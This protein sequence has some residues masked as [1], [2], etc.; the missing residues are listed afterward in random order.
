[1]CLHN[2][3]LYK[4]P[5]TDIHNNNIHPS[6]SNTK[7]RVQEPKHSIQS[8]RIVTQIVFYKKL[9]WKN[10]SPKRRK[11]M[12]GKEYCKTKDLFKKWKKTCIIKATSTETRKS[13]RKIT[14]E[15]SSKK[16]LTVI[17][18]PFMEN[19]QLHSFQPL[20]PI[21]IN[22]GTESSAQKLSANSTEV[23]QDKIELNYCFPNKNSEDSGI[24]QQTSGALP[25]LCNNRVRN[26]VITSVQQQSALQLFQANRDDFGEAY[27]QVQSTKED[28]D[29]SDQAKL[30]MSCGR[31]SVEDSKSGKDK[32]RCRFSMS[33]CKEMEGSKSSENGTCMSKSMKIQRNMEFA[34]CKRLVIDE[35]LEESVRKIRSTGTQTY[36]SFVDNF[37]CCCANARILERTCFEEHSSVNT[38]CKQPDA[39]GNHVSQT[40]NKCSRFSFSRL[41]RWRRPKQD[42]TQVLGSTN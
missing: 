41:C 7:R 28:R 26:L 27:S 33:K 2:L 1:M 15:V 9:H 36:C 13:C 4:S 29:D 20:Y 22:V 24:L 25:T 35:P 5:I 12:K 16:N 40:G 6:R 17:L 14:V 32:Q 31:S 3:E 18:N 23:V 38:I 11:L 34:C 8:R 37:Q 10:K 19:Q 39:G 21:T 30:R 42:T